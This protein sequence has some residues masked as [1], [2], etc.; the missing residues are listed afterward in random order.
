VLAHVLLDGVTYL[1]GHREPVA[2]VV[3]VEGAPSA[4]TASAALRAALDDLSGLDQRL[5]AGFAAVRFVAESGAAWAGPA[6]LYA[7][8]AKVAGTFE[9]TYAG[10]DPSDWPPPSSA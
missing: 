4:E 8:E 5:R 6:Y 2:R 7:F 1:A 10:E 3:E 9:T